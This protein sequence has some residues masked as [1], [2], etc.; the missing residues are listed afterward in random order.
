[1]PDIS[2]PNYDVCRQWIKKARD[3]HEEWETIK[4]GR[5][6]DIN[7]LLKFLVLKAADSWWPDLDVYLWW[8]IVKSEHEAENRR[9]ELSEQKRAA[10]LT[11]S[12]ED[13]AV[14]VPMAE[15]SSWQ[16]YKNHL[17]ESGWKNDSVEE[18]ENATISTLKRLS[19]D[20]IEIDPIKGLIVG[21]VQSGK[22][23]NMAALMAMAADWGWNFFV[24]LSG[25]IENLRKQ[26]QSR[27]FR[28]LNKPGNISWIGLEHLSKRVP[29]GQRAQDLR[30][31]ESSNTRYF[32]VCLKNSTRLKNLIEW[33]QYDPNKQQQ[34]KVIVID[35]EADQ[36]SINTNDINAAERKKINNLIVNLVQGNTSKNI[37]CPTS[38]KAMNY[39]SYT[40][41]P[42]ANF[43]NESVPESL[44]PKNFI[45]TLQP[46]PEYFGPKQ[47]FG[48]EGTDQCDGLNII[49]EISDDDFEYLRML[50]NSFVDDI[51]ESL[52]DAIC[53]FL[54]AAGAM[55]NFGYLKP[56]S[57]LV[58]TS[59]NQSHHQN[60][61]TAIR[62]WFDDKSDSD[63]LLSK[64]EEIWKRETGKLSIDSFRQSYPE[65]GRT[66]EE[67]N[68]YPKFSEITTEI[69]V[70][71]DQI[72]HISLGEDGELEYHSGIHLCI[73]NCA[74]HGEEGVFVRLC[75]PDQD[76]TPYPHPAP[77]FIVV[78]G[79]T[80][81]RG[82][83]IEGLV[84]TYF[85]R[86][87]CQADSLMQMGRWFGYRQGYELF[88]RIWMT[89]NTRTKF[90]FLAVLEE[91]LREDLFRFMGLGADPSEYGPRVKNTPTPSWMKITAKNKMQSAIQV[92][93]D[94]TGT[95]PQTIHFSTDA[96]ILKNNIDV[97]EAFLDGLGEYEVSNIATALVWRNVSF[98][99]I[100]NE[101]LSK[102]S[103]HSKSRVFNQID[104]FCEWVDKL[105]IENK[106]DEFS[107]WNIIAAGTINDS[108]N[109]DKCW[110][111]KGYPLGKVNRSKKIIKD[112]DYINIGVLRA[113]K[114][115]LA[116]VKFDKLS[117]DSQN[118]LSEKFASSDIEKLRKEAGVD[119]IP[120]LIIYKIDKNSQAKQ[121]KPDDKPQRETLNVS[122]DIIG[123]CINLPGVRKG[124]NYSQTLTIKLDNLNRN[125]F[126]DEE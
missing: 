15:R 73:D 81:S 83:T 111:I 72:S 102:F 6:N 98:K 26:T 115:L 108:D 44:Y 19:N 7:G 37:P 52:E 3:H 22:T 18:I 65:Y 49:R 17:L 87:S 42:Y 48:I 121:P 58:H 114:D 43:L 57:M 69:G 51:P 67:L 59:Q 9:I 93:M 90:E 32:T 88:P 10:V 122:E 33:M 50:H 110:N 39:I 12:K 38:V 97:A 101:L 103:F 53:W 84:S 95:R 16:L 45:R 27:L 94:F 55:R 123:L 109:S 113:P 23:A 78:G 35:D 28:D 5:Q 100:R 56:I 47:I 66:D 2:L 40:A 4:Y 60:V 118:K 107:K 74:K 70:L 54:C 25:T 29:M 62:E 20:T 75:Y 14:T 1:M 36:A 71:V 125:D 8:E 104:V 86:S 11:D 117:E 92:D 119:R 82:L 124:T 76:T 46:S 85:L 68:G 89:Q 96:N 61:A 21:Y 63:Y 24:V 34:M 79:N 91:D 126:E 41:T 31:E 13:S 116:D 30:L 64:C 99:N 112:T 80:L 77:A 105:R 120:Q 106:E